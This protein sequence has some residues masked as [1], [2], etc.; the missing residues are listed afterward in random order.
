VTSLEEAAAT[1]RVVIPGFLA[2]RVFYWRGLST[3]RTDLELI[4]WSLVASVP[5]YAVAL[6]IR[7]DDD[8]LTL[9]IAAGLGLVGG[10]VAARIWR[11]AIRRRPRLREYVA[12][13]AW[14]AVIGRAEGGW[15]Q[16]RTTDGVIY[17]GW[18]EVVAESAQTENLD[19]YL[20]DVSYVDGD[21]NRVRLEAAE[22]V[23][24]PR[25]SVVSAVRFLAN[26]PLAPKDPEEPA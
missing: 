15:F 10:E 4:L 11:W 21:G 14:D 20:R 3:Q 26:A 7:P 8:L 2:L 16:V 17:H 6:G 1:L 13:T 19:L 5:V 9:I 23:L 18:A 22:G 12:P 24:I 25:S